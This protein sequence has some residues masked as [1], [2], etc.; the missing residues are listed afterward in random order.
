MVNHASDIHP[1]DSA[2]NAILTHPPSRTKA[3]D[4]F[5]PRKSREAGERAANSPPQMRR[6]GAPS[7]GVVPNVWLGGPIKQ[8]SADL[9][10]RSAAFLAG[11]PRRSALPPRRGRRRAERRSAPH[12]RRWSLPATEP[13]GP[14][15]VRF[16]VFPGS[17]I[18]RQGTAFLR[19]GTHILR[20]DAA[21]PQFHAGSRGRALGVI[22]IYL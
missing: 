6:G 18:E 1:L 7:A 20:P 12:Q 3:P 13:A 14:G 19:N 22:G 15:R 11:G 5:L 2:H 4:P 17:G 9:F 16:L 8:G 10:L 21:V